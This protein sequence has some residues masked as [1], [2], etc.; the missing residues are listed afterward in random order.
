MEKIALAILPI[1]TVVVA[2][3]FAVM[4]FRQYLEKRHWHQFWWSFALFIFSFAAFSEGY[5][6]LLGWPT[7][8]YKFYYISAATLVA[9][10]GLGTIYLVFGNKSGHILAGIFVAGSV[11]FLIVTLKANVNTSLLVAGASVAGKAMPKYVRIFSPL[12]TIPG[13]LALFGGAIYSAI[14]IKNPKYHY[15]VVANYYIA[16]GTLVI[17]GA[18]GLARGGL[19]SALYAGDLIGIIIIFIGFLKASTLSASKHA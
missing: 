8:L 5:S 12:F 1:L 10:L 18:G 7:L 4:V 3:T 19:T 9:F 13:T 15:R 6:E 11:V 14:K 17:A 16:A 2:L